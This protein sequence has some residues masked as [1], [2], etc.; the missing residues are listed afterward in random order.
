MINTMNIPKAYSE[1]YSFINALGLEY[2][3]KIPNRIYEVIKEQRDKE[4]VV[5][6]HKDQ[7]I[8][9]GML[10]HEALALIAA[11]NL[12]YW[13]TDNEEKQRLKQAYMLNTEKENEKYSYDN[14]FSHK[15][16]SEDEEVENNLKENMQL[17]EY[18]EG[19]FKR[20]F[21]LIRRI[22]KRA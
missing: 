21:K 19:I 6:L 1:V 22:F 10:S 5:T 11:L 8:K 7:E 15:G 12:Q 14:M 13:C 17:I 2:K 3:E 16:K 18:K 20:I 4:Y 9:Q